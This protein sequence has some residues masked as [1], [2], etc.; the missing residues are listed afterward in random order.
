MSTR[1]TKELERH[2]PPRRFSDSPSSQI[3]GISEDIDK[4]VAKAGP[5]QDPFKRFDPAAPK[6]AHD[7]YPEKA[8]ELRHTESTTFFFWEAYGGELAPQLLVNGSTT[9]QR[10]RGRVARRETGTTSFFPECLLVNAMVKMNGLIQYYLE[11][12]NNGLTRNLPLTKLPH[13]FIGSSRTTIAP[14]IHR[15]NGG[16]IIRIPDLT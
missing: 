11:T 6:T 14:K 12:K 9:T 10:V 1:S 15:K 3:L 2:S 8:L 16:V 13:G 7:R 5:G 4:E